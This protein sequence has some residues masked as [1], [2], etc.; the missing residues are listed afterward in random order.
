[1]IITSQSTRVITRPV[2]QCPTRPKLPLKQQRWL[3]DYRQP[4]LA[5]ADR[6]CTPR[7]P[8]YGHLGTPHAS[9]ASRPNSPREPVREK[10]GYE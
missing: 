2:K 5:P 10:R 8:R 9:L 4:A 7:L 6:H 1:M 3:M